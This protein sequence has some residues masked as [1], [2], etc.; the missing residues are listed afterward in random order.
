MVKDYKSK[1]LDK[2]HLPNNNI[3][4]KKLGLFTLVLVLVFSIFLIGLQKEKPKIFVTQYGRLVDE[5]WGQGLLIRAEQV[6]YAPYAGRVTLLVE[7]KERV[8]TGKPILQLT[9]RDG[10]Q[11]FYSLAAGVVSFQIDGL[12]NNLHPKILEDFQQ[13][14]LNFRGKVIQVSNGERVNAGRPLFKIVDNYQLYLLVQAPADQVFRYSIGEKVW[15]NFDDLT[16]IGWLTQIVDHQNLFVIK[17]ERF[18]NEVIDKR[19]LELTV[20]TD[21]HTGVYVPRQAITQIDDAYGVYRIFDQRPVFTKVKQLGGNA[22]EVI[23]TGIERGVE[24]LANPLDIE[25]Y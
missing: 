6:V 12:E 7:D 21:A 13:N 24:I 5:F 15:L 3:F 22:T 14:Y 8:A 25:K 11:T 4:F 1:S 17:L 23:V 16:I 10:K 2:E 18:P 9:G 19:W 20:L